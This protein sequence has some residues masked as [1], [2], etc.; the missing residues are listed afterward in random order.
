MACRIDISQF[1]DKE[2][3]TYHVAMVLLR[4]SKNDEFWSLVYMI[5]DFDMESRVIIFKLTLYGAYCTE[6]QF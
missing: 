5:Y 4:V 3:Y 1:H 2:I 6:K